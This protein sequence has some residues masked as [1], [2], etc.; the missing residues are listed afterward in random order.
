[1]QVDSLHY[2]AQLK[3]LLIVLAPGTD[4]KQL[5][6]LVPD[7]AAAKRLSTDGAIAGVIVALTTGASLSS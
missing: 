7:L 3:Y 4:P 6:D 5:E 2:T 1:V